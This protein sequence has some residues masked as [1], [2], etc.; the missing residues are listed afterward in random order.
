MKRNNP[1]L[2]NKVQHFFFLW[3]YVWAVR[4][5]K[6]FKEMISRQFNILGAEDKKMTKTI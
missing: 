6:N 4:S 2:R 5:I 3:I 1:S